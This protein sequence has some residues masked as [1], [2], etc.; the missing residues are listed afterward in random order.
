[1]LRML[2][3]VICCG[4]FACGTNPE[5]QPSDPEQILTDFETAWDNQ[6]LAGLDACLSSDFFYELP[7]TEW[8]DYDGDGIIDTGFGEELY[9]QFADGTF[10]SADSVSLTL[11]GDG[12]EAWPGDST[13]ESVIMPR[14]FHLDVFYPDSTDESS[15]EWDF[16]VRPEGEGWI[17][18]L[19]ELRFDSLSLS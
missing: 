18:W 16:I 13:G 11:Y 3:L 19:M 2:I 8:S 10:D 1:M 7:S 9:L 17:I 6:D 4:M 14:Q 15:G 12:Y 5:E